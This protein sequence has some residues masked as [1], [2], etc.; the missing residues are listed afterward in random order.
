M[1][2]SLDNVLEF[3]LV[4]LMAFLVLD[5]C[6]QVFARYVLKNPS[7]YTDELARFLLI[8]VGLLGAAYAHGQKKHLAIDLL[9]QSLSPKGQKTL[10]VFIQFLIIAF[11]LSVLVIGGGR[12][13][14][15]TLYLEQSSSALQWPLGFVYLVI[16]LSGILIVYY[17]TYHL[18]Y[19]EIKKS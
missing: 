8:W 16:P 11:A 5:V 9:P 14:Y 1:K 10:E 2:K 12:L 19:S 15:V 6:W 13:V 17:S 4:G 7:S 3:V 18:F